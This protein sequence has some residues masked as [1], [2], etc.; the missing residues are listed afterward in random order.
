MDIQDFLN[1]YYADANDIVRTMVVSHYN[2]WQDI[3]EDSGDINLVINNKTTIY[4]W[5][6]ACAKRLSKTTF[7]RLKLFLKNLYADYAKTQIVRPET[8]QFIEKLSMADVVGETELTRY[9]F[10]NLDD[11]IH[12]ITYIGARVGLGQKTD[13]LNL[14]AYVVILWYGFTPNQAMEILKADLNNDKNAVLLREY[15]RLIIMEPKHYEIVRLFSEIDVYHSF[16]SHKTQRLKTSQYL[17]RG[18]RYETQNANRLSQVVM[19]FNDEA[20][21]GGK[22]LAI[23]AIPRNALYVRLYKQPN[24][25]RRSLRSAI[26]ADMGCDEIVANEYRQQYLRWLKVFG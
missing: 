25:P 6:N 16:P 12:Y 1:R 3:V 7:F 14:K 23:H 10:A 21:K 9:Y 24:I 18:E 15:D 19:A 2:V 26:Q 13:M 20:A 4:A 22:L 11:I 5:I 17:F 8:I